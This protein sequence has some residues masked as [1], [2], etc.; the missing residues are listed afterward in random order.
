MQFLYNSLVVWAL[1]MEDH[2]WAPPLLGCSPTRAWPNL[3]ETDSRHPAPTPRFIFEAAPSFWP[4]VEHRSSQAKNHA[5]SSFLE[6]TVHSSTAS[7]ALHPTDLPLVRLALITYSL[8]RGNTSAWQPLFPG[9]PVL[10]CDTERAVHSVTRAKN[11]GPK[12]TV[13]QFGDPLPRRREK[14]TTPG[15][16]QKREEGRKKN[17]KQ[18]YRSAILI[19][20]VYFPDHIQLQFCFLSFPVSEQHNSST[21]DPKVSTAPR[22]SPLISAGVQEVPHLSAFNHWALKSFSNPLFFQ[23]DSYFDWKKDFGRAV[24]TSQSRSPFQSGSTCGVPSSA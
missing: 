12:N 16:G 24:K 1:R 23:W 6:L 17:P 21:A 18:L 20:L 22:Q 7:P 8:R 10:S 4:S 11:H 3:A 15:E 19:F 14:G 5:P 9:L 2:S 13:P